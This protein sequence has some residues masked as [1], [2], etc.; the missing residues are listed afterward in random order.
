MSYSERTS[1]MWLISLFYPLT[2]HHLAV[3]ILD[4]NEQFISF[5]EYAFCV[6]SVI[7]MLVIFS[8]V[9]YSPKLHDVYI[10]QKM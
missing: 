9:V 8:V 5:R 7:G 2:H 10:E 3:L 6:L 1:K 4:I